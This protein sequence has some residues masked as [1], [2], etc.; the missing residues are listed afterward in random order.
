VEESFNL[1]GLSEVAE[2]RVGGFSLGMFQRF[3]IAVA[4]LGDPEILLLDEPV[5]GLD[6]EGT[7][8]IRSFLQDLAA[9]GRTILL[10]AI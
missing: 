9:E 6:P 2:K 10:R 5:N 3:G 8:W 1:V 4:M 7:R